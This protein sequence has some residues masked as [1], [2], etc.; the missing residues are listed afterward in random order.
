MENILDMV[1]IEP[2]IFK[3]EEEQLHRWTRTEVD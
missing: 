2:L 1:L 3:W